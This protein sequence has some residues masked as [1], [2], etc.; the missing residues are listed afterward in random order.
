VA[1]SAFGR[2]WRISRLLLAELL[3]VHF[4]AERESAMTHLARAID[5][6]KAMGMRPL[7]ERA[8]RLR[9]QAP[10]GPKP[11]APAYPDRLSE[12]EVEELLLIAQGRTNR[13]IAEALV[14]SINTVQRHV[15][16]ILDKASVN[17]RA[18]A[19]TYAH[20]HNLT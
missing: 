7:L 15:S 14:I 5:E 2:S 10:A 11:L 1:A 13:Q 16:N 19:A 4:A 6:L 17:N 3:L 12:R 8:L 20:R 9:E 18:E